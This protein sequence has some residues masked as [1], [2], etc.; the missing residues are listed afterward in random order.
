[1]ASALNISGHQENPPSLLANTIIIQVQFQND[2]SWEA[3]PDHLI[4]NSSPH[5]TLIIIRPPRYSP[6]DIAWYE[7]LLCFFHVLPSPEHKFHNIRPC[8]LVTAEFSAPRVLLNHCWHSVK[9]C[10]VSYGFRSSPTSDQLRE[11]ALLQCG[12]GGM[13][14]G[15]HTPWRPAHH[16][17]FLRPWAL[18]WGSSES[19]SFQHLLRPERCALL[20]RSTVKWGYLQ[21]LKWLG[22]SSPLRT[23]NKMRS[24]CLYGGGLAGLIQT[25]GDVWNL[26]TLLILPL[27]V[28][29]CSLA[30]RFR[31]SRIGY[32]SQA[33]LMWQKSCFSFPDLAKGA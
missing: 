22:L 1:M 26:A 18:L 12:E 32:T 30:M 17:Q 23:E 3:F 6:C 25:Q 7:S 2:L 15:P 20:H 16:L 14:W 11:V 8:A 29:A 27:P 24:L 28:D 10:W 9:M 31:C 5:V 13:I 33:A 21:R 4:Q 19:D